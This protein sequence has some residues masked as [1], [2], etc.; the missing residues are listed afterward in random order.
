MIWHIAKREL[1]D[2][3]NNLRFGLTTALLLGLMLT[4]A[5]VHLQEHPARLQTY[6]TASE[7]ARNALE[8]LTGSLYELAR[9]GPGRLYKKPSDLHFCAASSDTF[10]P[11]TVQ[12]KHHVW[13]NGD[14]KSFWRMVYPP[15]TPNLTNIRPAVM[16]VDWGF[17]SGYILSLVAL[18]LTFD[19]VSSERERGT[20]R[21]M[22]TNSMP[23]HV[24]LVGKFLGALFTLNIPFT[25][26]V[27][28]NLLV[29]STAST[30]HISASGWGRLG[31]IYCITLL[32]MCIFLALGLLVSARV[33]RSVVALVIL[34]LTWVTFVVFT[35][36][37]LAS[38][39]SRRAPL[40]SADELRARQK[41]V[42]E[43]QVEKYWNTLGGSEQENMR[44]G[45]DYVIK[46]VATQ[47]RLIDE[48][49]A[50]QVAQVKR[51]RSIT[52]ISPAAIFHYL[53]ES[54]AA[55]GFERHLQFLENA[56]RYAR[57]YMEFIVYTDKADP[58][59][60]HFVGVR[61]GMSQRAVI[62]ESIPV[63]EDTRSLTR[64]FDSTATEL[65]LLVLFLIVLLLG[66]YLTFV[67][68]EV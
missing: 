27:L 12:G 48:H 40:M 30:V 10:L 58:E 42:N 23:R 43:E 56:Q 68:V 67:R 18:L 14:L 3:L 32:Y 9:Q 26:A 11:D 47:Q 64:N 8:T 15:A 55:T 52:R 45:S 21:L 65:L 1:Y 19:S 50:R 5:I 4:N 39:A 7:E 2:N 20:L 34:L 46:D 37:L 16:K 54:F 38:I 25:F 66:S 61:E 59:S 44:A 51:A 36:N 33:G 63:F 22:L 17:I 13:V 41:Q 53:L 57:E 49:L 60:L 6:L 24:V 28:M 35:P 29:I 62:P 31:I